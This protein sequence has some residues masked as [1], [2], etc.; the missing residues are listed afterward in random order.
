MPWNL[1]SDT[2]RGHQYQAHGS[3][4]SLP[5]LCFHRHHSQASFGTDTVVKSSHFLCNVRKTSRLVQTLLQTV[6]I[7]R[8]WRYLGNQA[9]YI[10]LQPLFYPKTKIHRYVPRLHTK[11]ISTRPAYVTLEPV[12]RMRTSV[13]LNAGFSVDEQI[14]TAQFRLSKARGRI[15]FALCGSWVPAGSL[16]VAALVLPVLSKASKCFYW[17]FDR[18]RQS[19][20]SNPL[21]QALATGWFRREMRQPPFLARQGNIEIIWRRATI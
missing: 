9:A 20:C 2:Y 3:C 15:I 13:K 11:K 6:N 17:S 4:I 18:S 1:N 19:P 7:S 8:P 21:L 14:L 16:L 10:P 5:L 12:K